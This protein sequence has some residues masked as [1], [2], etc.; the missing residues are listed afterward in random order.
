MNLL[1]TFC[2]TSRY[3][4]REAGGGEGLAPVSG[5]EIPP[6]GST[7]DSRMGDSVWNLD[8]LPHAGSYL[9]LINDK[10]FTQL[11][12]L[13]KSFIFLI[14]YEAPSQDAPGLLIISSLSLGF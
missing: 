6:S 14:I 12:W 7:S 13:W 2:G 9:L 3:S 11:V 8:K 5:I 1:G 10:N 4:S